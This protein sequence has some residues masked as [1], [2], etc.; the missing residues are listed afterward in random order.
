MLL[1]KWLEGESEGFT[2]VLPDSVL[3]PE[4]TGALV[5]NVKGP[6][7]GFALAKCRISQT[8]AGIDLDYEPFAP[9]NWPRNM[10]L[11]TM[12]ITTV[13]GGPNEVY[14]RNLDED[15]ASAK[16]EIDFRPGIT[17][18]QFDISQ[19]RRSVSDPTERLQ[20]INARIGQG[21]FRANLQVR[22]NGKCALTEI[23]NDTILRASH[24]KPWAQ[25][26]Q[27]ERLDQNNGLLLAAHVDALFDQYLITFTDSGKLI[28]S[29]EISISDRSALSLP[30]K[31][32]MKLTT[33]E[34]RYLQIHNQAFL[35]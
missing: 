11:G 23:A 32:C 7:R 17:L 5:H 1:I 21:K 3:S 19:V 26:D 31:L 30:D 13:D 15:F 29:S 14:W 27:N 6:R 16:V 22:W 2:D 20:L 8:V 4:S 28:W 25:C 10:L 35:Q 24:I 9:F 33:E 34:K 12:R 18:A